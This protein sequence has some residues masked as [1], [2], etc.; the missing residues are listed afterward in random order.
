MSSS[1]IHQVLTTAYCAQ[2]LVAISINSGSDLI[3]S[4]FSLTIRYQESR[5]TSRNQRMER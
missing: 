2:W 1:G 4:Y 5:Q 3:T